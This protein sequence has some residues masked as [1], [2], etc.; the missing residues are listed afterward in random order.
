MNEALTCTGWTE[1]FIFNC[2]TCNQASNL[3]DIFPGVDDSIIWAV[4][5]V[6]GAAF[7]GFI[8]CF[9]VRKR[10]QLQD[11]VLPP[12]TEKKQNQQPHAWWIPHFGGYGAYHPQVDLPPPPGLD[13]PFI[14]SA[15]SNSGENS[16]SPLGNNNQMFVSV[17]NLPPTT[18]INNLMVPAVP[19]PF[20]A[21]ANPLAQATF[22]NIISKPSNVIGVA[23]G[24]ILVARY[25]FH[26]VNSD[27]L[28]V[29][30]GA[31]LHGIEQNGDWWTCSDP[32][33]GK[34]G[35]IPTSYVEPKR[36]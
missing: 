35:L 20:I 32:E 10:R 31:L 29:S 14:T 6:L 18:P 8:I 22:D 34:L 19:S 27:E 30:K 5:G 21:P 16:G 28:D 17:N 15:S 2:E 9:A 4:I 36:F 13:S 24:M 12:I 23:N 33:T 7:I 26:G 1:D 11:N 3:N 25:S